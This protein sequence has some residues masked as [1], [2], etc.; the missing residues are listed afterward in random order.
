MKLLRTLFFLA[1]AL[2]TTSSYALDPWIPTDSEMASLPAFCKAR[3]NEG[4]PE[5]KQWES[6]LGRDYGHTHHYC[7][8][9]NFLNRYYRSRSKQGKSL[10]LNNARGNFDYM[11]EHAA[12]TYSLMPDVYSNLGTV[13]SLMN[14]PAQAI[15]H[16]S[17]AIALDPRQPKAYNALGDFYVRI[18]QPAKALEIVTEGLRHNPDTK[19]LQRRYTELGGKLPYPE[20]IAPMPAETQAAKPEEKVVS[21]PT[22]PDKPTASTPAVVPAVE[23]T[24]PSKIGSPTNPYCRFCPD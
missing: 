11:V 8:G 9:I 19:S 6:S 4:S 18:K 21:T 7:A 2:N 5:Y 20:P 1:L 24:T 23:T 12:P 22:N 10:N 3:F 16:F 17:K 13:Y 14:Q 15:T